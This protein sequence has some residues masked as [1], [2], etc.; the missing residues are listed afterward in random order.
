MDRNSQSADN[1]ADLLRPEEFARRFP[2]LVTFGSLRAQLWRSAHNGLDAAGA[3]IRKYP[4]ANARRP[5]VFIDPA[6]Y[7]QWLRSDAKAAA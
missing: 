5:K 1:L 4:S 6:R 3:V 7:A 2:N